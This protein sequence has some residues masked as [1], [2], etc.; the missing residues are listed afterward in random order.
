MREGDRLRVLAHPDPVVLEEELLSRVERGHGPE[1][2]TRT[3][4]V[5]P[6]TRLAEHVQ[7]RLTTR[8]P[9]WLGLEVL[10]LS[11]LATSVLLDQPGVSPRRC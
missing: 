11:S 9:A 2:A 4:I 10:H 6:T 1:M 5:T 8:R 7:R 3:L